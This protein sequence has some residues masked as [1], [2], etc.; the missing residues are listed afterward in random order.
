M[1]TRTNGAN[2]QAAL[3]GKYRKGPA[4]SRLT[5]PNP[6]FSLAAGER[7]RRVGTRYHNVEVEV[8]TSRLK[9]LKHV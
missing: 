2:E 1:G 7:K 3:S 4:R 8:R 9:G 6:P 5:K